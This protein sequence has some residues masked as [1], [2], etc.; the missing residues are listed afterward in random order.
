MGERCQLSSPIL[1]LSPSFHGKAS[2]SP[3]GSSIGPD[4][5]ELRLQAMEFQKTPLVIGI[6][7]MFSYLSGVTFF[8]DML[9]VMVDPRVKLGAGGRV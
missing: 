9:T 3:R 1:L 7:T 5:G 6:V 8:L 4:R 2:S